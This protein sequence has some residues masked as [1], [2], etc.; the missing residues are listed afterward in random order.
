MQIRLFKPRIREDAISAATDVMRSGWVGMGPKVAEFERDFAKFVGVDRAVALNTGT[1]AVHLAVKLL[2]LSAGD[3]VITSAAT[4][5]GAN[6]TLLYEHLTPVFA[7]I[8]IR[9]GNMTAETIAAKIT[10]R[11]RAIMLVHF[12]G[13]ACDLDGIGELARQRGL[14]IVEDCAHACG[15]KYRGRRIGASGNLCAFSFDPIKN[16][17]TGDGGMIT[18]LSPQE[19]ERARTIRYMG[20]SRDA[21]ARVNAVGRQVRPWEYEVSEIGYRYHM[22]DIA[23]AMGIVHLRSLDE[24]NQQRAAI[25]RCYC[26][27]LRSVPGVR[28]PEYEGDRESSFHLLWIL[29]ENR[30]VLAE[31]LGKAG[32]ITGVHYARNDGYA[33]FRDVRTALPATDAFCSRVLSLPLHVELREEEIQ[34]VARQIQE[35]W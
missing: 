3:E 21:F 34:Y 27:L 28:V 22:N 18:G 31:K 23:A 8:D 6:Q 9:T 17:T 11:T 30:D 7:D 13:Y 12:A 25:A 15:A 1:S 14:K 4:F 20:L 2:G 19:H 26:D 29:A 16:L 35:G 33:V 5:V 32:V 24:E 10:P